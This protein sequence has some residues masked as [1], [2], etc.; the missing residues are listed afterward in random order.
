MTI[1]TNMLLCELPNFI[2][3]VNSEL[4]NLCVREISNTFMD[5]F[6]NRTCYHEPQMRLLIDVWARFRSTNNCTQSDWVLAFVLEY[7]DR[8]VEMFGTAM[9]QYFI[10]N[11]GYEP[12]GTNIS[13]GEKLENNSRTFTV[14]ESERLLIWLVCYND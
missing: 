7:F 11:Y 8:M 13:L 3:F 10:T 6:N 5:R 9:V 12:N 4:A 2:Y 1:H 14:R